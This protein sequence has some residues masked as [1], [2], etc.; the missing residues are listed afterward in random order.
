MI[1]I[2]PVFFDCCPVPIAVID[3]DGAIQQVNQAFALLVGRPQESVLDQAFSSFIYVQSGAGR[4][5]GHPWTAEGK[6]LGSRERPCCLK[7]VALD[8]DGK[9]SAI[10]ILD[11]TNVPEHAPVSIHT[12]RLESLGTLAGGIAHDLNNLLTGVL[13][14]VSYLRLALPEAGP[15]ADSLEAIEDGARRAASLTQQILSFVQ[16]KTSEFR[17]TNLYRVVQ[18]GSALIRGALHNSTTLEVNVGDEQLF[19]EGDESKLSQI[20]MNLVINARDA[21]PDGG[22]ICVTLSR[23][24]VDSEYRLKR[25]EIDSGEWVRM[26]ISDSGV[27]MT[28]EVRERIFE[29]F[30]TTKSERG[31]GIG[32]ATVQSIV[33]D[34]H[35]HVFCS[36]QLGRGTTFDVFLPCCDTGRGEVTPRD[37]GELPGGEE[38]ILVVDDEEVVRTIIQRSL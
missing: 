17:P 36:S 5:E 1:D 10:V 18:S 9:L 8:A 21:M 7:G 33:R 14:H 25:P 29:P 22:R 35:G 13:G 31:T 20:F 4:V 37:E 34:H 28:P 2:S 19:V 15:H 32:L 3:S 12:Q 26:Q 23:V 16:V 38:R 30:F 6:I 27:G 11:D 24:V